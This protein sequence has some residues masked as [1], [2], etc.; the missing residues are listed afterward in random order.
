MI[1]QAVFKLIALIIW[2]AGWTIYGLFG[3]PLVYGWPDKIWH[4]FLNLGFII[5]FFGLAR[6]PV[7]HATLSK[8]VDLIGLCFAI[9]NMVDFISPW[10]SAF[11]FQWNEYIFAIIT[12]LIVARGNR[13]KRKPVADFKHFFSAVKPP[14]LEEISSGNDHHLPRNSVAG[15]SESC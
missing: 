9:S 2:V 5:L 7:R 4:G 12:I 3:D 11:K 14:E 15:N 6:L 10:G 8:K 1:D 13:R